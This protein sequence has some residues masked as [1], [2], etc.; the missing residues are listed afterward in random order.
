MQKSKNY[1]ERKFASMQN[2]VELLW[3]NTAR[4]SLR[5]AAGIVHLVFCNADLEL[6][7]RF[8]TELCSER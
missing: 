7:H 4:L 2:S 1:K 8:R 6:L 3:S 5:Q